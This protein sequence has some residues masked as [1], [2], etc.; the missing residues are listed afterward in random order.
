MTE[1]KK[2]TNQKPKNLN[3]KAKE[4]VHY[5]NAGYVTSPFLQTHA[6]LRCFIKSLTLSFVVKIIFPEP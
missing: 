1:Q 2:K 3:S 4:K 6:V 5:K